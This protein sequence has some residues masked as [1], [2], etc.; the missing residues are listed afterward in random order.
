MNKV[1]FEFSGQS[2]NG[3]VSKALPGDLLWRLE[4]AIEREE[5]ERTTFKN[6]EMSIQQMQYR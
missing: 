2:V 1:S 6:K 3:E 4:R 5:A